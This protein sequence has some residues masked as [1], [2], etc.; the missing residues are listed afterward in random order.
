MANVVLS[1]LAPNEKVRF[2]LANAEFELGGNAKKS[3][4]T[5][6][7]EVIANA[8][9]HP[10][11][12]VEAPPGD[13]VVRYRPGT[14]D[15]KQDPLS[16]EGP[17]ARLPFDEAAVKKLEDAKLEQLNPVAIEAGADQDKSVSE[18]GIAETLSAAEKADET[19]DLSVEAKK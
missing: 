8:T 14:V 18:G 9:V 16:S 15:P 3:F 6:D 11:L 1:D 13:V 17:N 2:L 19:R 4:S 12:K 10:W 5:D 7:P